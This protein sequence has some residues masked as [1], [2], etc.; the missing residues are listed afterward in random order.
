MLCVMSLPFSGGCFLHT[1]S[2]SGLNSWRTIV[3]WD[4]S[5]VG[6]LG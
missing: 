4:C 6:L 1:W 5:D 3:V 2:F